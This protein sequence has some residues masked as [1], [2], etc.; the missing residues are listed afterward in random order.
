MCG[1]GSKS[2]LSAVTGASSA[3]VPFQKRASSERLQAP[4]QPHQPS[5][6]S[7][8]MQAPGVQ[9]P[10]IFSNQ[11][12][13]EGNQC[14]SHATSV[15][16]QGFRGKTEEASPA[17]CDGH[18]RHNYRLGQQPASHRAAPSSMAS[19]VDVNILD[20]QSAP[21]HGSAG[22]GTAAEA[23]G[24]LQPAELSEEETVISDVPQRPRKQP[25]AGGA[26]VRRKR[27]THEMAVRQ[28]ARPAAAS[29]LKE[30]E[31][32]REGERALRA[33]CRARRQAEL[34][35]RSRKAAEGSAADSLPLH[36]SSGLDGSQGAAWGLATMLQVRPSGLCSRRIMRRSSHTAPALSFRSGQLWACL[37]WHGCTRH[38][39]F[40]Q[41]VLGL[42]QACC[43][44]KG[45]VQRASSAGLHSQAARCPGRSQGP[46]MMSSM[47]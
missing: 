47:P 19:G 12:M 37:H 41:S 22:P 29:D 10:K 40:L 26:L 39:A 32:G 1:R 33:R 20:A 9:H 42:K 45:P 31:L 13:S 36:E 34:A 14:Q 17:H 28:A 15:A 6:G 30:G 46:L 27:A 5:P 23:T 11:S 18:S 24:S 2:G 7:P 8:C 44:R 3:F 4:E 35:A 16:E 43:C 25:R 38:R 21:P